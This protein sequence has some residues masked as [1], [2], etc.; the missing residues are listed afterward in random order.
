MP[1]PKYHTQRSKFLIN[2]WAFLREL[3]GIAGDKIGK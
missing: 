1:V 2:F 3:S